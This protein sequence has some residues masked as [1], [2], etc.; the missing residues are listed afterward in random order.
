[1]RPDQVPKYHI[2]ACASCSRSLAML[3]AAAR[4]IISDIIPPRATRYGRTPIDDRTV[5][6]GMA[7]CLG[8]GV[9]YGK[10]PASLG[11]Q[12]S[13]LRR[14]MI[15]WQ[16]AGAW[17]DI[18]AAITATVLATDRSCFPSRSA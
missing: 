13:T 2:A 6:A 16:A 3:E 17:D 18:V 4:R 11:I 12:G 7:W 8:N 15:E 5:V 10:A 9:K 14:R 1:M